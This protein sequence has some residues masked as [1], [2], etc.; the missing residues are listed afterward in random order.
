MVVQKNSK[1]EFAITLS[2]ANHLKIILK[3]SAIIMKLAT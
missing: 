2:T 1:P 3:E